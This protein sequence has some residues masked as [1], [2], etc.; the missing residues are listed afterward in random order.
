MAETLKALSAYRSA[1]DGALAEAFREFPERLDTELSGPSKVALKH[2][3]DYSLR[4]GKRIRGSLAA[5]TYDE[6]AGTHLD[7][8]GIQLGAALELMQS[9]LLILDDVMDKSALRR[10]EPTV[11]ELYLQQTN[12]KV[13][14]HEAQMMAVN[15]GQLAQHMASLVVAD[16]EVPAES[17]RQV[18]RLMHTN[19]VTT[20]I[21]QIDDMYQQI[22]RTV[23]E[24]DIMRKY[25]YK[26]SYYTFINPMQCGFALAG[27]G[28]PA[29]L[30][31]C[32]KFG[33]PAGVAF[34]LHDDYLGIFAD[35][36]TLGKPN[37]DDIREG[38]FTLQMFHALRHGKPEHSKQLKRILGSDTADE[39]D[40]MTVRTI[41]E[42]SGAVHYTQDIAAHLAAEAQA[43]LESSDWST[44]FKHMLH[45]LV[46]FSVA[47]Q[48]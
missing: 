34:M 17:L 24:P 38:K 48:A 19:I 41:L 18:M 8:P 6:A 15:I 47:R 5:A 14:L 33:L 7:K 32:R 29:A 44:Q 26:S 37:L 43:M 12:P 21:G 9:Y 36:K 11:H 20:G 28:D 27:K 13:D 30:G 25:Q 10:G 23:S 40:L 46:D 35:P 22:G 16:I 42:E 39:K 2:L 45:A 1:I 3:E 31:T 4:G